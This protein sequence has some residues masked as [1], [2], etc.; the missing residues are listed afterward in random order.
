[1]KQAIMF[2]AGNIGRGFIGL[3][4]E[5][6]GYHVKFADVVMPLVDEINRRGEYVVHVVA[7]ECTDETVK[8]IS[9]I[10]SQDPQLA[11]EIVKKV[12][13]RGP[14]L[15][16]SDFINRRL[17][18]GSDTALTGALQAAIDATD[19]NQAFTDASY[20]VT[21]QK[22]GSLYKYQKA[23]EGSM[24]TAAPGYLIQ[25]DVLASLGNILTVRDDT[26][27]VRAYGCVRNSR[28]TVLSQAWCEATV[29]RTIEYVDPTNVPED[30][31]RPEANPLKNGATR[32]LTDINRIMGR[33]LRIISFRWLDKWDI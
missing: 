29:Q 5:R 15:N 26:F 19:I 8:N 6:A 2:G 16:M 12:R 1:M 25:S 23:A 18:G 11:R 14:F 24:Y 4:L 22:N 31:D 21:V 3:L 27:T 20:N 32:K 28:K 17:D 30:S 10:N 13:E 7:D 33:K 9:A